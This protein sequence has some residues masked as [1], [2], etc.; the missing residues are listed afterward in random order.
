M[1]DLAGTLRRALLELESERNRIDGQIAAIQSVLGGGGGR[2]G[3]RPGST[4]RRPMSP[5]ARRAVSQR[6]KA[7]W[8]KRRAAKAKSAKKEGRA[9]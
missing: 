9:A 6:M 8:A 1:A 3:R 2:R 4:G 7:Y 5:A